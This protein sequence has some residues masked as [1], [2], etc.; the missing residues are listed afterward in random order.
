MGLKP[1]SGERWAFGDFVIDT[2]AAQLLRQGCAIDLRPKSFEVLCR[3]VENAEQVLSRDDLAAVW[4]GRVATD[5]SIAQCISDIRR[6]LSDA[7]QRMLQTVPRRGYVLKVPVRMQMPMPMQMQINAA[8]PQLSPTQPQA[9]AVVAGRPSIVVMPFTNISEGARLDMLARGFTEDVITG[10]ARYPQLFVIGRE[11]AL[12][13]SE[14]A[15]DARAMGQAAGVRFVL[16]GS[17]RWSPGQIRITAKLVQAENGAVVWADRFD[18]AEDQF[19]TFQDEIVA[20]IVAALV[21]SVDRQSHQHARHGGTESLSAYELFLQGRELRRTATP[22]NFPQAELLLERAVA[23]DPD[24][25]PAHGELAYLQH[26]YMGLHTGTLGRAEKLELGLRHAR[27]AYELAPDL[28]FASLVLGN[29][30]MRAHDLAAAERWSRS[31]IRLGPGDAENYAG[32][33]NVLSFAGRSEE[34]V[35]L[36]HTAN[37]YDPIVPPFHEHY[38]ARALAWTGRFEQALPVAQS[39]IGRAPGFWPC[40][41]VLVVILAH[42]GR[43]SEAATALAEM[44]QQ[45]GFG[46]P[47]DYLDRGDTVPG[48]EFERM[49]EGLRLAGLVDG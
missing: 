10:L 38:L 44:R 32:L 35:D 8:P 41:L 34:A 19:F 27:R 40:K 26:Y 25:A 42:L 20:R 14:S 29:L 43:S 2:K 45:C 9:P 37:R 13:F 33:A 15:S 28:P 49:R 6:A 47:Q 11:S 36:M 23:L 4:Q 24:F 5:E 16:Q 48:P 21:E 31:A 22:A 7:D 46:A 39:C 17:L 12:A 18:G 3:L 30:H 1:Q